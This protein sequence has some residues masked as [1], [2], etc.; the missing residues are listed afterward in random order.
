MGLLPCVLRS[1]LSFL[2]LEDRDADTDTT[3]N[4]SG[5]TT[6]EFCGSDLASHMEVD[7]TVTQQGGKAELQQYMESLLWTESVLGLTMALISVTTALPA[8]TDNGVI[9]SIASVLSNKPRSQMYYA[10]RFGGSDVSKNDLKRVSVAR[11]HID[12]LV[13]QILDTAITNHSGAFVAF[14]DQG[15]AEAAL[16]RLLDELQIMSDPVSTDSSLQSIAEETAAQ[17]Q[18]SMETDA[19]MVVDTHEIMP[20]P[21]ALQE[22][23]SE[24]ELDSAAISIPSSEEGSSDGSEEKASPVPA[25]V[26]LTIISSEARTAVTEGQ[27]W[28]IRSVP[29]A[30]T[31]LIHQLLSLI[32]SWVQDTQQDSGDHLHGQLLKGPLFARIF[33][34]LF[35]N[36]AVL[37][38]AL[39]SQTVVLLSD[40]VNNDPAPPGMLGHMLSSGIA[41]LALRSCLDPLLLYSSELLMGVSCL[42]SACCL[43]QEGIDMVMRVNPFEHL[44]SLLLDEKYYYPYSKFFMTEVPNHFGVRYYTDV[45]SSRASFL[46]GGVL[47]CSMLL[48]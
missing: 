31:V 11:V 13:V 8:L 28:R 33:G 44:F 27:G 35:S 6:S 39:M 17:V 45:T 46:S 23:K 15:G 24:T 21:P 26:A 43:M 42:T 3:A 10:T 48:V 36:A 19:M 1:V 16:V 5:T 7:T 20:P 25:P 4:A 2:Q 12:S 9:S 41:D 47:C 32:I 37:S 34:V 30:S 18:A 14:K 22:S 38:S 29:P 40:I